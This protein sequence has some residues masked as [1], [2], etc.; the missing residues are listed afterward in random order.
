LV[1]R[2]VPAI[3]M[4]AMNILASILSAAYFAI[5]AIMAP[6]AHLVIRM[7]ATSMRVTVS[8][9]F[10]AVQRI[11]VPR[12]CQVT[13]INV[14]NDENTQLIYAAFPYIYRGRSK[15]PDTSSMCYGF[16]CG[17]GWYQILYALSED[18]T[19]YLMRHPSLNLE[20]MQV[21]NKFGNLRF[22]VDGGD[23]ATEVIISR[24]RQHAD[25]ICEITG[26]A[27]NLSDPIN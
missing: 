5:Q 1:K 8:I 14:M 7:D 27:K 11:P 15:A 26:E 12:A 22:Y 2:A 25:V 18:L 4:G 6:Q 21:K 3:R 19:N 24:A 13:R 10:I 17:D 23:A 9:A 16:E 20:V